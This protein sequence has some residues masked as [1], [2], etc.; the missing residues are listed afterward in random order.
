[1]SSMILGEE[2]TRVYKLNAMTTVKVKSVK[3]AQDVY[4]HT[5]TVVHERS[6]L[7][8][9][10][11]PDKEAVANL[12]SGINLEDEQTELNLGGKE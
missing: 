11:F 2:S 6:T 7:E 9:L 4:T 8:P 3:K 1:M 5:I 10:Q 12:V